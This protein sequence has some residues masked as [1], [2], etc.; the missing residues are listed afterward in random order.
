MYFYVKKV[1]NMQGKLSEQKQRDL[2]RPM[3]EDFIDMSFFLARKSI[4][5]ILKKSFLCII[6]IKVHQV[7][8]PE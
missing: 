4:G 1:A 6:Q 2:F 8:Q 3:L 7:F 5:N